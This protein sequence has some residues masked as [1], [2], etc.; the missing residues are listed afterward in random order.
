MLSHVRL[1]ATSWTE[2]T[3]CFS[4]WNSSGK[5]TGVG[6]H[7]LL[8]RI[9][10]GVKARS[11]VLKTDSLRSESFSSVQ[12]LSHVRLFANPWT[13]ACQASLSITNSRSLPKLMSI[14]SEIL[15][16][17]FIF[18]HPLLLLPS[19]FPNIRVFSYE[20][21]SCIRRPKY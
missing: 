13:A 8:Q 1:F 3:R 4:P 10:P 16:N 21:A 15:S 2:A 19:I 20:S 9:Y 17:H 11:P 12:S 6:S 18:H 14:E 5:N 7:S